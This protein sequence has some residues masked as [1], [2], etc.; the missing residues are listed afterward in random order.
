MLPA[1]RVLQQ[2]SL[3]G[4]GFHRLYHRGSVDSTWARIEEERLGGLLRY[5]RRATAL[6]TVL[7][8]GS[9]LRRDSP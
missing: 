6:S 1:R 3:G 4:G 8:Q 7:G 2:S 9:N 5:S